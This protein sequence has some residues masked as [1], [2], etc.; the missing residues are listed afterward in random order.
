MAAATANRGGTEGTSYE[1]QVENYSIISGTPKT[2]IPKI[3]H[4]L[5]E[6]RPGSVFFWD[7]D[8][9]MTHEDQMR[10]LRL[11]GQEVLPAVR[12]IGKELGLKSSFEVDPATGKPIPEVPEGEPMVRTS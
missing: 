4:V 5:E 11:M 9:A 3:R 12:E 7:G 6:L 10:S 2:V 8:G 1:E